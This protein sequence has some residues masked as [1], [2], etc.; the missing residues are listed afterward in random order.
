MVSKTRAKP[1]NLCLGVLSCLSDAFSE[2]CLIIFLFV[3][4]TLSHLAFKFARFFRLQAPCFLCSQLY[5]RSWFS[6]DS[7]CDAH[8]LEISCLSYCQRHN[9][10]G[11][12][13]DFCQRCELSFPH[14]TQEDLKSDRGECLCCFRKTGNARILHKVKG[15]E[16]V[17][18][19]KEQLSDMTSL[20]YLEDKGYREL[21]TMSDSESESKIRSDYR[22]ASRDTDA[23]NP[24]FNTGVSNMKDVVCASVIPEKVIRTIPDMSTNSIVHSD[25]KIGLVES[26]EVA[27]SH[28]SVGH[29]L[30]EIN[31]NHMG[32]SGSRGSLSAVSRSVPQPVMMEESSKSKGTLFF[33]FNMIFIMHPHVP[34]ECKHVTI[35]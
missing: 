34:L 21:T 10:L 26:S 19:R 5:R 22:R 1:R 3:T 20:I 27:S 11:F 7:I 13:Q 32:A 35:T 4:A 8:K 9:N 30:E 31:W 14:S 15:K 16:K 6:G 2:W 23:N 24:S 17:S 18:E 12:A 25:K 28:A 33:L 29:G